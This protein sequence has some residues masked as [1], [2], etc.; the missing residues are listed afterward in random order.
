M[1][2]PKP[3][4][5]PTDVTVVTTITTV[6]RVNEEGIPVSS[7]TTARVDCDRPVNTKVAMTI[8]KIAA[9]QFADAPE[10]ESTSE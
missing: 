2:Q 6:V 7:D 10:E 9:R 4:G 1:N 3:V 5:I 8:G